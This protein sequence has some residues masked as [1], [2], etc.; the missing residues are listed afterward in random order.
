MSLPTFLTLLTLEQSFCAY[1]PPASWHTSSPVS[2]CSCMCM[3]N[4]L[5]SSSSL[6]VCQGCSLIFFFDRSTN[7]QI[8]FDRSDS[9]QLIICFEE[10]NFIQGLQGGGHEP[11]SG[12]RKPDSIFFFDRSTN[13]QIVFDRSDSVQLISLPR[14]ADRKTV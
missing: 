6:R 3:C 4:Q 12:F 14:V 1:A 11:S 2:H 10:R 9:V 8:V 5:H 7:V 13:V